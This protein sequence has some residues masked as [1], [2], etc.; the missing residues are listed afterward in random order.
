MK[1]TDLP[2]AFERHRDLAYSSEKQKLLMQLELVGLGGPAAAPTWDM[3]QQISHPHRAFQH[4]STAS[5]PAI[6]QWLLPGFCLPGFTQLL[7]LVDPNPE[8]QRK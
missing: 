4:I 5:R 2:S 7:L 3:S 1:V 8:P 6:V